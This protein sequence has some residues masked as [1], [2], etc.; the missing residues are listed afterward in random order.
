MRLLASFFWLLLI[1]ASFTS[2]KKELTAKDGE[3]HLRAFD[4]ELITISKQL[5]NSESVV[6]LEQ[7]FSIKKL[8][9]P[10]RYRTNSKDTP[11]PFEKLKGIYQYDSLTNGCYKFATA[12][13]III[14]F[15]FR[16]LK[17]SK[18]KFIIASYVEAV[19]VWGPMFPT[20]ADIKLEI[21]KKTVAS[22][23]SK[24]ELNYQV[25]TQ[26]NTTIQFGHYAFRIDLR[27]K[28]SRRKS[29]M[30]LDL[31]LEKAGKTILNCTSDMKVSQT[32]FNGTLFDKVNLYCAA[33][34]IIIR[35][36]ANYG[37]IDP[38]SHDFI[39][40]FNRQIDISV[41]SEQKA[42]IGRIVLKDRSNTNRLNFAIIYSDGTSAWLD[43]FLFFMKELMNV[44]C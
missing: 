25:P 19:S 13:S 29:K 39:N 11:F 32:E 42:S 9:V 31:A 5:K 38:A 15:P 34:P 1:V 30:F 8:P 18:A 10:F 27:S 6:A 21:D 44:K 4:N 20:Q 14:I 35:A 23:K 41:E 36:K 26:S 7:L 33:F 43:D 28:L 16:T 2:C 24:G 17:H 40:E 12:D 22:I 37:A 3:K